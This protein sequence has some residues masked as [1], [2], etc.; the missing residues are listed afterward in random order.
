MI[1]DNHRLSRY[2]AARADQR[3]CDETRRQTDQIELSLAGSVF[4]S[5]VATGMRLSARE[6]IDSGDCQSFRAD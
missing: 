3:R 1:L 4:P 2:R 6:N 5:N